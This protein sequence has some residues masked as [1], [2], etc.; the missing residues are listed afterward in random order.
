VSKGGGTSKTTQTTAPWSG[1]QP[2]ITDILKRGQTL[3]NQEP[4]YYGGP[5]TVGP[6]QAEGNAWQQVG[7]YDTN[8]FGS[9][10]TLQYGNATGALQNSLGGD[11]TLG[12]MSGTLAPAAT[13][14][15]Q[16]GF[17][18]PNTSGITGVQI[19]QAN[20]Q[21]RSFGTTLD[22][23]GNSPQFGTAGTLDARAAYE[24]ALSGQPD[25]QGTQ[26][27]IDAANAP[28][29][30]Q[31]NEQIMPA[32]NQKATFTNN[33]TGGVKAL[34]RVL[35]EIGQRMSENA[36]TINNQERLRALDAQQQAAAQVAGGGL[37]SY[38]L[39]LQT[40][41]GERGLEQQAAGMGLTADQLRAQYGMQGAQ[42]GLQQQGLLQD[43]NS[44][45]Q[46]NLLGYGSLAGGLS[47]QQGQQSLQAAGLFPSIYDVGRN[48][49]N[50]SLQYANY[51][52]ALR[53]DALTA[54]QS[55]FNYLRDQPYNNMSWYGSLV[56][57]TASPYG[58]ATMTAP[59][60]SRASGALGGALMGSQI[61]AGIGSGYGGWGALL[62]GL[63]GYFG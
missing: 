10:P 50:D 32:L 25:Y 58:S 60:P 21:D 6:T 43:T 37:Q 57:G 2:Y 54:D 38:G 48:P 31:F 13:S 26:A 47:A 8:V 42:L 1:A 61:G 11:T 3:S 49:G 24:K 59:A 34:N 45:Y 16:G 63:A 5:L 51:D 17:R 27:A 44:Q 14:A 40:A 33:E 46:Q 7:Q 28:I 29:L 41:Q 52:R 18:A 56:N 20:I 39:G 12:T 4:S 55:R 35:P 23:N 30:R 19:P 36:D 62:G 15:I 53:E 9:Q 22:V